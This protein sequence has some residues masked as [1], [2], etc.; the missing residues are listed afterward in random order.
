MGLLDSILGAVT[1]NSQSSAS[2]GH[3]VVAILGSL[4]E[5]NGG[6]QGLM[7]KFSEGGLGEVFSSWVSTG[8]NQPVSGEQISKVLGSDQLQSVASGLGLDPSK[9]S[10]MLAEYLPMIVDKMTPNGQV[11]AGADS[12]GGLAAMLPS[13]LASLAGG[14]SK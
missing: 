7:S 10:G 9:A 4:L 8:Q 11:E 12:A 3:P 13:L 2:G 1:G 5:K 6:V 14:G